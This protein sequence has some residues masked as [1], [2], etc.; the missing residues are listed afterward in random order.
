[1]GKVPGCPAPRPQRARG[2]D[3][4]QVLRRLV[5][6]PDVE[7]T[8]FTGHDHC[9]CIQKHSGPVRATPEDF[10]RED[11]RGGVIATLPAVHISDQLATFFCGDTPESNSVGAF[12]VQVS[13][14]EVVCLGLL[15]NFFC[16]CLILGEGPILQLLHHFCRP[17]RGS[18]FQERQ[19]MTS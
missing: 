11:T 19:Q 2:R 12:T 15:S 13:L 18:I 4:L 5:G 3:D 6:L 10:P 14:E 9:G 1:V 16:P 17:V 7:L 8:C